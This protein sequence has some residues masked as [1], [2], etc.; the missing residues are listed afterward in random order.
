MTRSRGLVVIP[1]SQR[2]KALK[3]WV[4]KS[5][6]TRLSPAQNQGVNIVGTLVGVN[7]L[8]IHDVADWGTHQRC[9][10]RRAYPWLLWPRLVL[11]AVVAL[12]Q[13]DIFNGQR[14]FVEHP[15]H[16]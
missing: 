3:V 1:D 10:C 12:H 2:C 7:R 5:L 4:M 14:S 9:R 13:R 6:Q 16:T 8:E 11:T 15:A